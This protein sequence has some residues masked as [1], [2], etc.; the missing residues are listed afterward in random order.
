MSQELSPNALAFIALTNEYCHAI[1]TAQPQEPYRP[2]S[3]LQFVHS[4]LKLLPRIY[5]VATDL[6]DNK[7]DWTDEF[8]ESSLDENIYDQMRH[9][10]SQIMCDDDVYLETNL[11]DM[12][13]SDTP[14][15]AT[16]SECLA[17]LYQEFYNLVHAVQDIP[18][19]L[20]VNLIDACMYNF[21][22]YWGQ[23]LCNVLRAMHTIYHEFIH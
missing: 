8:I 21:R 3:N 6:F 2:L 5:I 20:Q 1:E 19:E 10:L 13:Y 17:D 22:E 4:M 12:Q 15:S 11:D 9:K 7:G 18:T 16:I 23:T 14:V